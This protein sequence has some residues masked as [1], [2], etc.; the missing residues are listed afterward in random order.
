MKS[1]KMQ[2][3]ERNNE[4][5][6]VE[7]ESIKNI[8]TKRKQEMKN[9]RKSNKNLRDK[10]HHRVSKLRERISGFEDKMKE[11]DSSVKE[12]VK[13]KIL[14]TKYQEIWDTMK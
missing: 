4:K 7:I 13:L 6:E 1:V 11:M 8:K 5:N 10:S 9:L 14:V 3:V 2:T 12:N